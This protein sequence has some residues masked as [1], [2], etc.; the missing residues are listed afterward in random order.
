MQDVK[1]GLVTF[2]AQ[3]TGGP[4]DYKGDDMKTAHRGM[5]ITNAEFD[6]LARDLKASLQKLSV[7]QREQG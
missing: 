7:P 1:D 3:A 4:K 5:K 6:A 2:I